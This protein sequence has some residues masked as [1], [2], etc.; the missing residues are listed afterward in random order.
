MSTAR[1]DQAAA[2]WDEEPRRVALSQ[3]I[4]RAIVAQV[5]VNSEMTAIDFGCGTG[6][7]TLALA[8]HITRIT[9]IDTSTGMLDKLAEKARTLGADHVTSQCLDLT[10]DPPPADLRA[11]LLVSAMALHHIENISSLFA[12]FRALLSP[13]GWIALADL[14]T[15]DGTFHPDP[16]GVYHHG[17]DRAWLADHL[18]K[19]GF[20][21]LTAVTAHV[22]DRPDAERTVR[23][24]P[25]FLVSGKLS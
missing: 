22:I 20:T 9:G 21:N 23:Q 5:P 7:V 25:V 24:Y 11:D 2:T 1:F 13:G 4:V 19:L 10:A 17:I 14:D 12:A 8:E 3:A 15:E 18:A 16:T 6:L